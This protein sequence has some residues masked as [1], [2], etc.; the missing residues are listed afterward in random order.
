MD[1]QVAKSNKN[2]SEYRSKFYSIYHNSI[3]PTF[4]RFEK[5]RRV[6]LMELCFFELICLSF[7]IFSVKSI[8][9]S[10]TSDIFIVEFFKVLGPFFAVLVFV[11][12][13][14]LP[15]HYSGEFASK[16]KHACMRKVLSAF[17]DL[18]W[19][20]DTA[21]NSDSQ[22]RQSQLFS[23]YNRRC[24]YDSFSGVYNGVKFKI[25]ETYMYYESGS[26]KNKQTVSVFKGVVIKFLS[27]KDIRNTTIIATKGDNNVRNKHTLG[28][29]SLISCGV[30][31]IP[32]GGVIT[33]SNIIYAVVITLLVVGIVYFISSLI[34]GDNQEVLE[35]IKL[36]DPEFSK[37]Y[38]AYSSNQ[39]EGRYLITPAFMQRFKN[40]QTAFGSKKAK[41]SFYGENLMFAISTNRNLFEI[42]SLFRNLNNP[43]QMTRFFN[44]LSSILALVDYFKLD[45]KTGI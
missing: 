36:E 16:L 15:I 21:L 23:I 44:E 28:I 40:L 33:I 41:C 6:K 45:E 12:L 24:N 43:K 30:C 17:G 1:L 25:D 29:L 18:S 4:E 8:C 35:E 37:K 39:V 22:L 14:W 26:G 7:F 27:N 19:Y 3:V 31:L 13:I 42:G 5:E 20:E 9:S 32:S 34:S 11:A 10:T 2:M 38:R